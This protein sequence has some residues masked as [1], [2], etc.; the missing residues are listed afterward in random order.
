MACFSHKSVCS[1]FQQRS[2]F[3]GKPVNDRFDERQDVSPEYRRSYCTIEAFLLDICASDVSGGIFSL[4]VTTCT[5]YAISLVC[6]CWKGVD[7][8]HEWM[9]PRQELETTFAS[10]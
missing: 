3:S 7:F 4:R 10:K 6:E 5:R 8:V 9:C 2:H 1:H